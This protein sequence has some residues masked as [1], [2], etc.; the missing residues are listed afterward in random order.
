MPFY[1]SPVGQAIFFVAFLSG[2]GADQKTIVC[3]TTTLEPW[4]RGRSAAPASKRARS[5][6]QR[7]T[8][9]RLRQWNAP[10]SGASTICIGAAFAGDHSDKSGLLVLKR[11]RSTRI[12]S[13]RDFG[14]LVT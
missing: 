13:A 6:W 2:D 8:V 14:G 11:H 9:C 3:A 12:V 7:A 5:E 4:N 1:A 10:S